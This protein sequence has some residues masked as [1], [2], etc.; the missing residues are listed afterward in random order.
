M[1]PSPA[2]SLV[3]VATSRTSWAP[4]FSNTSSTSISRAIVTPSL[5]IVGRAELLVEHDVA[6]LRAERHLDRVGDGVDAV[7]QRGPRLRVVLELLVSHC[8]QFLL[9]VLSRSRAAAL[10]DLGEDV[11]LAQ[12]EQVVAV[13]LDLGA[14]VL[15]VEDLVALAR[16]RAG[17]ARRPRSAPSPTAT[18]LPFWGFSLAVSGRTMPLAVVSSSS[19]AWTISRSP[20]GFSFIRSLPPYCCGF[21]S[22]LPA[23]AW[24]STH[25]SAKRSSECSRAALSCQARSESGDSDQSAASSRQPS[26]SAMPSP[27]FRITQSWFQA[28]TGR[29]ERG[30]RVHPGLR[31]VHVPLVEDRGDRP[32]CPRT[33]ASGRCRRARPTRRPRAGAAARPAWSSSRTRGRRAASSAR[34]SARAASRRRPRRRRSSST[35]V[36][37][38]APPLRPALWS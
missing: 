10:D 27:P 19:I 11:R 20:R 37:D 25:E 13:D 32:S 36:L 21:E 33:G 22:S 38:P 30:E 17:G 16:R 24:H 35:D 1:V 18:T 14:A 9:R 31:R 34:C 4:W 12:H 28:K 7:L 5:V 6:A 3:A 23:G 2:T 26:S 8:L 15:A 29:S